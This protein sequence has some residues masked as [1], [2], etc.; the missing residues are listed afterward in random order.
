[1]KATVNLNNSRVRRFH[2]LINAEEHSWKED[3]IRTI[4]Q[5]FDADVILKIK[6]PNYEEEDFIAWTQEKQGVFTV[7]SAY[8]LALELQNETLP[9]SRTNLNGDRGLWKTF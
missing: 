4:F 9:N 3:M 2:Q 5:P 7:R 6:L 1:M 8:N